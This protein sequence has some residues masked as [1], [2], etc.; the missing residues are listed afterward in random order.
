MERRIGHRI[1]HRLG[2][3]VF[4]VSLMSEAKRSLKRCPAFI[5]NT[6]RNELIKYKSFLQSIQVAHSPSIDALHEV[7]TTSI[8][9]HDMTSGDP[10]SL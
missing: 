3:L 5:G 9:C 10:L 8:L 6:V 2:R 4:G 1:E 7:L